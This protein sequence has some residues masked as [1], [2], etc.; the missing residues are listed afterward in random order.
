MAA[1]E[2]GQRRIGDWIVGQLLGSGSFAVVWKARHRAT[3]Q[4]AAIKEINLTRLNARLR[5]SLESEVAILKRMSHP[6]VVRLYEVLEAHGRLFIV[7]E[8]CAGG[9]L[10]QLIKGRGRLPEPV[11]R[12]L[13][14]D[15][16]AGLRELW[17][18]H[19]VHVSF[20]VL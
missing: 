3:G 19:L 15:L 20:G 16:A 11:V 1:P 13:M 7:M 8:Y 9:D 2:D 12:R 18:N 14:T 10:A 4:P 5:Q 17:T 6:N